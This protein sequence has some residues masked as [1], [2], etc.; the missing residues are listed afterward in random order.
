VIRWSAHLSML[1]AELPLAERP[2]AAHRAG[3]DFVESWWPAPAEADGFAHELRRYG[4]DLVCLNCFGGD[5]ERGERGFLNL[6]ERYEQTLADFAA[7][8][9]YG[10]RVR[11]SAINVLVGRALPDVPLARQHAVAVSTLRDIAAEAAAAGVT[12]L[13]EA[14]NERDVPGSLVPTPPA[15]V[16]LIEEVGS[17]AVA[18]LYDAYHA[19]AAGYS[20]AAQAAELVDLI[21]HVQVADYPGR[22]APGSGSLDLDALLE[23]LE[24]GGYRGAVGLEFASAA[25]IASLVEI[26]SPYDRSMGGRR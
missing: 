4:F 17:D 10:A 16:A 9:A 12:V 15:A 14:L 1:F 7:A 5:I 25:P 22:G 20:P 6:A 13:V 23:A 11:A 8:L 21:G 3:F 19:A 26:V 18:L 24:R 2:A